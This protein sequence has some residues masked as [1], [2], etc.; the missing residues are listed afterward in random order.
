MLIGIHHSNDGGFS[1]RWIEYCK[2]RDIPYKIVDAY[3][4]CVVKDLI[5]CHVFMWQYNQSYYKDWLFAKQLIFSLEVSGKKVFPDFRTGWHFDDK[6]GQKYLFE[7]IGAPF[8][9]SY[10]F[11]T[12]AEAEAWA[13]QAIFPKVFKLRGGAGSSNVQLVSTRND[14]IRL[15]SKA[16]GDGFS[17]YD[18]FEKLKEAIRQKKVGNNGWKDVIRPIYYGLKKYPNDLAKF[19]GYEKGYVLFQDF[20]PNNSCDIRVIVINNKA[21]AIKRLVRNGDFRASGSGYIVYERHHIDPRCIQISFEVSRKLKLQSAAYDYVFDE[22]GNPLI[23]EVSYGFLPSAYDKCPGYWD[24][25]GIWNDGHF[26]PYG[27]MVDMMVD[28]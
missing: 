12:K 27:W 25:D 1:D 17:Q 20:I 15:I 2:S 26:N 4:S 18:W 10:V 8:V 13:N 5:D 16:F 28:K 7:A 14:A 9:P 24:Q 21:F 19:R 11:Y 6:I 3:S 23:V 22:S